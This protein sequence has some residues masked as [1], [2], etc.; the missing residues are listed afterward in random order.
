M[1]KLIPLFL[2]TILYTGTISAGGFQINEHGA[3]AMAMAG[4]FTGL[5]NDPSA[6]FFNPA[7]ITQLTGTNIMAGVTFIKPIS[8]F[9]GPSPSVTE[10][11]LEDQIFNP[12]NF[13]VT[14]Q[15]SNDLHVGFG[16]N[17]P[18][19]LGTLWD[20]NW[21]GKYMAIETEIRTFFF[22]PVISYKISDQLS[23]GVGPVFAF[24][25]VLISRKTRS[26]SLNPFNKDV[27]IELSGDGT[28]WGFSA[29]LLYKPL[30]ELSL[31]LSYRSETKFSFEGDAN[32]EGPDQ[33]KPLLPAGA[34][35]APLSTPQNIT[36][37]LA[38]SLMS[39]LI[40]T[41]DF[42]YIGWSSYDK[43]ELTFDDVVDENGGKLVQTSVRDYDDTWIARLGG[44]YNLDESWDLR[45][46]IFFDNNPVKDER[47]DPTLPDSDRWGFNLG[48]GY[49]I[50]EQL[51]FDF[52]YL[53]LRFS[54][55]KINNSLEEYSTG[56]A[57]F[58]GVYN[59]TAHLFGLNFSYS[60]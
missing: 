57:K 15:L 46:G 35:S 6:V 13:Y 28:A 4:A 52:A 40:V 12:I 45:G 2:I 47:V 56:D 38:T 3:R 11:E 39:N 49:K 54:E 20:E 59:S 5:A 60:L 55:R 48:F 51:S 53:F 18:Y 8:T 23:I 1:K 26:G 31:G 9:R 19:G 10:W 25:D 34:I 16:V 32:V 27:F 22:N 37:G 14:H 30:N 41:A 50:T 42:Q 17:N 7:G 44:E 24:G 29:G 21:V 36:F 58:N 33:F 43:L